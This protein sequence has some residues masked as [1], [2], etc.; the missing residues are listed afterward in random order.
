MSTKSCS[1]NIGDDAKQNR[2]II[3]LLSKCDLA[4]G[5]P[6]TV[7]HC[8]TVALSLYKFKMLLDFD[9]VLAKPMKLVLLLSIRINN[10]QYKCGCHTSINTHWQPSVSIRLLF[11][12]KIVFSISARL[13][14]IYSHKSSQ[15]YMPTV[16]STRNT[17]DRHFYFNRTTATYM[18]KKSYIY[19]QTGTCRIIL[20]YSIPH[21][22]VMCVL[23][24]FFCFGKLSKMY[25]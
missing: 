11:I 8:A 9:N 24:F 21:M 6:S 12:K 3:L 7:F 4:P 13:A 1:V 23:F 19:T 22:H 20:H 17:N 16:Y 25:F 18:R 2:N 15:L 14:T 10:C 5:L